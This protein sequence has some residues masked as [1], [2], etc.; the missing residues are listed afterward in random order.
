MKGKVA[1]LFPGQGSQVVGMGK[2]LYDA[3]ASAREVF[4]IADEVCGKEISRLCFEGPMEELTITNDLQPAITAVSL[5]CLHV[6]R[7]SG[8]SAEI[9]AG[10]SL[11]EY[12]AL[13]SA[14]VLTDKDTLRLVSKRGQLM[15]CEAEANPGGMVAVMG[16]GIEEVEVIVN[17]ASQEGPLAVANHNT[18]EQIVITGA[19]QALAKAT[20]LVKERGK[21]AIPLKVSGAWHSPLMQ[22]AVEEFRDYMEG[23]DFL[24]PSST[25][26]FNATAREE[27]DPAAIKELMARQLVS[28][29]RWY[30]IVVSMLDGGVEHF[31]EVGPK[32]V[33]IGLVRKIAPKDKE[34]HYWPAGDLRGIEAFLNAQ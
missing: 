11:G 9:C 24:P 8:S 13:A 20:K 33:L 26:L 10:H 14:G 21:K 5:A 27:R 23:I 2:D 17:E 7:E 29:V 1:L 28:P 22:G 19:K 12:A 15:Q 6:L 30:D 31:V 3:F 32:T 25:V 18:A 16:M 34:I 4:S